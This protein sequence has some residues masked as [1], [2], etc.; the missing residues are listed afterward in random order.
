MAVDDCIIDD[1][2][3]NAERIIDSSW[4]E[5]DYQPAIFFLVAHN[6]TMQGFPTG[7]S[8][9]NVDISGAITSEKLGDA[10]VTYASQGGQQNSTSDYSQTYY[11]KRFEE[12][13][14]RNN[15]G[16]ITL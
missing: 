11:G 1:E 10:A 8:V 12:I 13:L 7:E 4:I 15:P 9:R 16:V 3:V 14:K 5:E 2:I 6:L